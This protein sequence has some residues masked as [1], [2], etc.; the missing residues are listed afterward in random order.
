M[1]QSMIR[2]RHIQQPPTTN[3]ATATALLN[4]AADL[5]TGESSPLMNANRRS[6]E[7]KPLEQLDNSS[8]KE[9]AVA[10]IAAASF[11]SSIFAMLIEHNPVVYV[12]G[13]IGAGIAPYAAF[14][15]QKITQADALAE[16][17]ER[18]A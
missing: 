11:F 4:P 15:Q 9:K 16:T 5:E 6:G 17:N 18:G 14:Q 3:M 1:A 8:I 7:D 10:G 13:I 2:L 12:S